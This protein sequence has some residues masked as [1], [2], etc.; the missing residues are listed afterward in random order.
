MGT[1][2]VT[3]SPLPAVGDEVWL[4]RSSPPALVVLAGVLTLVPV[5]TGKLQLLDV[6]CLLVLPFILVW[7]VRDRL[8]VA[9]LS[10][11]G[12]WAV[13]Q[14]V[15]DLAN[16]LGPRFS[17]Q[18]AAAVTIAGLVPVLVWAARG[19]MR[20][21]CFIQSGIAAGTVVGW[22]VVAHVPV[23]TTAGWKYALDVPVALAVL[24]LADVHWRTGRRVPSLLALAMVAVLGLATDSRHLAAVAVLTALLMVVPRRPAQRRP[25][26]FATGA[27]VVLV[28]GVLSGAFLRSASSGWIGERTGEQVVRYG[29]SPFSFLVNV[30]P[31]MFQELY[32]FTQRPLLGWGSQP[33]MDGMTFARSLSFLQS[34]GVRRDDIAQNWTDLPVPGVAA[35]STAV[36]SVMRAGLAGVPFWAFATVLALVAGIVAISRRSSPLVAFWTM[37]VVWNMFFEPMTARYH[38]ELGAYLALVLV[39]L[40]RE[41]PPPEV[42]ATAPGAR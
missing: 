23:T 15:S 12:V 11:L 35:H 38:L 21:M 24:A 4:A 33:R 36:D 19:E 13:G 14:V 42:D 31:E 8:L 39:S 17:L 40:R 1:S 26:A 16:H 3:T 5:I 27:G 25:R 18:V 32:L 22:V 34:I 37:L 7:V 30:R 41:R 28:L 29:S 2:V 9:L 10:A 6:V 20:R